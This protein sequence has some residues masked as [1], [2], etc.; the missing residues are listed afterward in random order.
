VRKKGSRDFRGGV[1]REPPGSKV[2]LKFDGREQGVAM[3]CDGWAPV[4]TRG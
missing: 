3:R 4:R 1:T 2:T